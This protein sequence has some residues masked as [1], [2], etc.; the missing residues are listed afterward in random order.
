MISVIMQLGK[1]IYL[2]EH[3]EVVDC[4]VEKIYERNFFKNTNLLLHKFSKF[5]KSCENL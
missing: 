3:F 1:S 5:K 2:T 4:Y